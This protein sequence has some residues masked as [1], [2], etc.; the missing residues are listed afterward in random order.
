[1]VCKLC[2]SGAEMAVPIVTYTDEQAAAELRRNPGVVWSSEDPTEATHETVQYMCSLIAGRPVAGLPAEFEQ[3][4]EAQFIKHPFDWNVLYQATAA[5]YR[6]P[7]AGPGIWDPNQQ[8]T[9]SAAIWQWVKRNLE[10]VHHSKLFGI[11][12]SLGPM[13]QLLIRPDAVLK[14]RRPK[15]DCAVF[16]CLECSMLNCRDLNWELVTVAVDPRQPGIYSHVYPRVIL[17][18]GRRIALDASHGKYPGWEVPDAHVSAKQVWDREG[19]PIE[20]QDPPVQGYA[21]LHGMDYLYGGADSRGLGQDTCDDSGCYDTSGGSSDPIITSSG[22]TGAVPI[23]SSGSL[24][25]NYGPSNPVSIPPANTPTAGLPQFCA[26]EGWVY[27]PSTDLC[28][29]PAGQSSS[30][31]PLSA[32][33]IATDIAAL[34]AGASNV[35]KIVTGQTG[36]T[37]NT[38]NLLLLAGAALVVVLLI[39]SMGKK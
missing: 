8:Q 38:S 2:H 27:N 5:A 18:D 33:S 11:R 28:Q 36:T 19:N 39:S 1:M 12:D 34:T 9:C 13:L 37:I 6:W 26:G 25:T 22:D 10:F 4:I 15:G 32:A 24:P 14:M 16:T 3:V 23:T 30:Y 35:A 21:G 17:E 29:P 7:S 20:D 31:S